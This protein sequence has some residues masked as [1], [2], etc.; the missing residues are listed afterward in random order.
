M[1]SETCEE[2][3]ESSGCISHTEAEFSRKI[4]HRRGHTD[5]TSS[6]CFEV[7]RFLLRFRTQKKPL[8][9]CWETWTPS[10][11]DTQLSQVRQISWHQPIYGILPSVKEKMMLWSDSSTELFNTGFFRESN[12]THI[13]QKTATNSLRVPQMAMCGEW[14][15]TIKCSFSCP[16]SPPCCL[17]GLLCGPALYSPMSSLSPWTLLRSLPDRLR[18]GIAQC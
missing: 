17:W 5:T 2:T 8:A 1:H 10:S 18:T 16:H 6:L 15:G 3:T 12:S 13:I 7:S 4:R 11:A 9:F 14:T